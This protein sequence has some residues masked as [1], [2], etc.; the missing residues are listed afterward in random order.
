MCAFSFKGIARIRISNYTASY[1]VLAGGSLLTRGSLL[2]RGSLLARG[3]LLHPA[4]SM[5]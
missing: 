3:S 4:K 2:L 1:K 5:S